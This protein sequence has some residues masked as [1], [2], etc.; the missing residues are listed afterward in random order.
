[1]VQNWNRVVT[2]KDKVY[3]LGDVAIPRKGLKVLERLNG[4]KVLV[5]GNHD[6]FKLKDYLP[7]FEDIH[8][9]IKLSN[10]YLTHIPIHI[11]NVPKWCRQNIH[12]H[13]HK[14]T[15]EN[16]IYR[17]VS[18]EMID[19]TPIEMDQIIAEATEMGF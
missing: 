3:H 6:I 1:M 16:P 18:V 17:N 2:D 15:M 12:G 8:G 4:R 5:R 10:F 13:I 9:V 19:A 11:D 14:N 7:Y